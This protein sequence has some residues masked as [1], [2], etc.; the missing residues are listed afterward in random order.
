MGNNVFNGP[1]GGG[2]GAV[3]YA[4]IVAALGYVQYEVSNF[5][6]PGHACRHNLNTWHMQEWV[7]LGPSAAS[8]HDGWRGQNVADRPS[9]RPAWTLGTDTKWR[10]G[11]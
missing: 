8:Q 3:T 10:G 9:K 4:S 1:F 11:S 5:A 6:R 2:G 7:G